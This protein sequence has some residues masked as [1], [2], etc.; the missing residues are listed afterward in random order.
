MKQSKLRKLVTALTIAAYSYADP[1][2]AQYA[3]GPTGFD[4]SEIDKMK[5]TCLS[6]EQQQFYN[7]RMRANK[8]NTEASVG[9]GAQ[10]AN[11]SAKHAQESQARDINSGASASVSNCDGVIRSYFQWK[12]A[13]LYADAMKSTGLVNADAAKSVGLAN[14]STNRVVGLASADA[15]KSVGIANSNAQMYAGIAGAAGGVLGSLFTSGNQKAAVKAQAEAEV[16]KAKILA[17]VEIEKARMQYDLMRGQNQPS[18]STYQQPSYAQRPYIEPAYPSASYPQSQYA[19]QSYPPQNYQQTA[20][21]QPNPQQNYRQN[22][23]GQPYPPQSNVQQPYVQPYPQKSHQTAL[24]STSTIGNKSGNQQ[25]NN[26]TSLY[27]YIASL[28]LL[29]DPS[30][31][32]GSVIIMSQTSPRVCT[33]PSSIMPSGSYIFDGTRLVKY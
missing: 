12:Q 30:C 2:S 20:Y 27:R 19:Q 4:T 5:E 33:F 1:S 13:Q 6:I 7:D 28:R 15:F 17:Q 25:S 22:T 10:G 23:Y 31:Q 16:E 24:A 26:A 3:S 11:A 14:A 8:T 32:P 18:A 21:G 9:Y 29:E